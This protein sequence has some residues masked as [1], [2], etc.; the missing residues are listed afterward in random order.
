MYPCAGRE[1]EEAELF[2]GVDVAVVVLLYSTNGLDVFSDVNLAWVILTDCRP[3]ES[4]RAMLAALLFESRGFPFLYA[5]IQLVDG[6]VKSSDPPFQLVQF[7][8]ST[9]ATM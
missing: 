1:D 8:Q 6:E 7:S 5:Q 3:M 2:E 4:C 9:F